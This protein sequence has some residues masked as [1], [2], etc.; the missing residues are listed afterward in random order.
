MSYDITF[1]KQQRPLEL[2]PQDIY[3]KVLRSVE[4]NDYDPT[5]VPVPSLVNVM[6]MCLLQLGALVAALQNSLRVMAERARVGAG[7]AR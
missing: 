4:S 5:R 6:E 3:L 7:V 1:W 2:P